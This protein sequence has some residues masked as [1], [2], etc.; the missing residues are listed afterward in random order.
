MYFLGSEL[1]AS[2]QVDFLHLAKPQFSGKSS[3]QVKSKDT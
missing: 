1:R 3:L 2:P